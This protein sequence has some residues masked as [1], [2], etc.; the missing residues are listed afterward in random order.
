MRQC[1]IIDLPPISFHEGGDE[2]Q[3]CALGLM[4]IGHNSLHQ[5]ERIARSDDD[6]CGSHQL[7]RLMTV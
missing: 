3:Q 1:V 5:L 6:L 2:Q 7:I 4:E